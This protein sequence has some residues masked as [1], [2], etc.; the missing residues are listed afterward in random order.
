MFSIER[1]NYRAKN[2]HTSSHVDASLS[3]SGVFVG[4][5]VAQEMPADYGAVLKALDRFRAALDQLGKSH[6]QTSAK[7]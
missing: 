7:R 1:R 5:A 3:V 6:T 4:N 2:T